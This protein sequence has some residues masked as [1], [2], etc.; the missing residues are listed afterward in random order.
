MSTYN[1]KG[2]MLFRLGANGIETQTYDKKYYLAV[3]NNNHN[4]V[5]MIYRDS[6]THTIY[7]L[8]DGKEFLE[9]VKNYFF[10]DYDGH[11]VEV[12]VDG[13]KSN[14]GLAT[15]DLTQ[16]KFLVS[17]KIWSDICDEFKVE[18]NWAN[19]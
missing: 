2:L 8:I 1:S 14:L 18:V 11:I 6:F 5:D 16:G 17:S 15:G 12:F 3:N 9:S 19:K 4:F 10:T 13:Y 7:D